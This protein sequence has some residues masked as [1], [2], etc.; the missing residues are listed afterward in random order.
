MPAI[1]CDQSKSVV[2]QVK[3]PLSAIICISSINIG[4]LQTS[5]R[6]LDICISGT[7]NL[8]KSTFGM[9]L[10]CFWNTFCLILFE[11]RILGR[12]KKEYPASEAFSCFKTLITFAKSTCAQEARPANEQC[13]NR[14]KSQEYSD[15]KLYLADYTIWIL[16]FIINRCATCR[17]PQNFS[18]V[19]LRYISTSREA[20]FVSH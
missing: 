5:S 4:A 13:F 12:N 3:K 18:A 19:Q 2:K 6:V 15:S 11:G 8:N 20:I 16:N 7:A 9:Q 10:L 1:L 14:K 17:I